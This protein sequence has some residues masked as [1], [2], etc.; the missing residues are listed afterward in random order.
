MMLRRSARAGEL[1]PR[2]ATDRSLL[3]DPFP[4]YD[5]LRAQG[6]L[7]RGRVVDATASHAVASEVLR[8]PVF[9]VGINAESLSPTARRMIALAVDAKHPGPAEPPSMLAVDPPQHTK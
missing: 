8:S 7:V 5:E 4:A 1:G 9:R 2:L 6:S 3:D